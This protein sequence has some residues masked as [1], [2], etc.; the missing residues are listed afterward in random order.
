MR[1]KEALEYIEDIGLKRGSVLGLD[2]IKNLCGELGNPQDKLKFVHIAGTN[3]KGSTLA[4]ISTILTCSGYRVGRYISPTIREYRERFQVDSRIISQS[5]FRELTEEVKNACES[6]TQKGYE[7]PTV[8][9]I[10]TAIAFLFFVKKKCDIVV[11][12]TGMGG[13]D[14][15][16]NVVSTTLVSVITSISMDHMQYLGDT[17]TEITSRKCGIIKKGIPVVSAEQRPDSEKVIRDVCE[18]KNSVLRMLSKADISSIKYGMNKQSFKYSGIRYEIPLAG[19]WQVE[20]AALAVMC[21]QVLSENGYQKIT[22]ESIKQGLMKTVWPAR[23]QVV[24]KKPLMI[25]DGAHNEDA[26]LRL[27]QSIDMYLKDKKK[28]YIL[29][30]FRDKEVDKVLSTIVGDGRMVFT[31]CA[32]DNPRAMRPV[33]LAE[34][35]GR[36]NRNVTC[37]DSVD[38][39]V[40]FATSMAGKD[41][42]IIACGSLAYL[43]RILDIV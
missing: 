6:L 18:R 22:T 21:V 32:P 24:S 38:E 42:V 28:I 11:L 34:V 13:T 25:I 16:T 7:H 41:D 17:L 5:V 39:A 23:F 26:A 14:D 37:C 43:G 29:G 27:R 3:G 31:C 1:Y 9:E 33:E 36:Y 10:E 20:N 12:E 4:Y 8:F 15:A 35:A 40:E 30:M 19:V 2:S